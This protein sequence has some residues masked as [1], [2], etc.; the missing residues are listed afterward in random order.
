MINI[1]KTPINQ[2]P[3][4]DFIIHGR[5]WTLP[6]T[7]VHE[8]PCSTKKVLHGRRPAFQVYAW[9]PSMTVHPHFKHCMQPSPI[10]D[11]NKKVFNLALN[12]FSS[13]IT[14]R[15][16]GRLFQVAAAALEK[17]RSPSLVRH[18]VD[19]LTRC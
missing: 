2:K 5:S 14:L 16:S 1:C 13:G 6:L 11:E 15:C 3:V 9:T 18:T 19:L 8:R 7:S 12:C 10:K 4:T 17:Q